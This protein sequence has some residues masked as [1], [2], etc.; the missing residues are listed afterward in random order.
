MALAGLAAL[1]SLRVSNLRLARLKLAIEIREDLPSYL[2]REWD[3]M[4]R[5]KAEL[6]TANHF[7]PTW[8][9]WSLGTVLV[10]ESILIIYL[11][12][13]ITYHLTVP[14]ALATALVFV[15]NV[16]RRIRTRNKFM[17]DPHS[18]GS[19]DLRACREA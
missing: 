13:S 1:V 5:H 18:E 9:P 3:A 11:L 19:T 14:F 10:S 12:P 15:A 8:L 17:E 16:R 2:H 6:V 4:I 7:F